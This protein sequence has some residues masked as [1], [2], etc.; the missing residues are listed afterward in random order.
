MEILNRKARHDYFVLET[1]ECVIELLGNEVKS[2]R[3]GSC[4]I[5]DSYAIIKNNELFII[6]MF[7]KQYE[8][9]SFN[10]ESET[11]SRKLLIH[12]KEIKKL[13]EYIN[14]QGHTLIPLKVYFVRGKVKVLIGVCKGKKNYDKR[15]T[16]KERDVN[17][18]IEK[19]LKNK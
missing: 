3:N 17:R 7:I 15:N 2:I 5:K 14:L 19:E 1:L 16:L 9:A 13:S 18:R 6:N 4:N 10:V 8:N 12:K 11:R